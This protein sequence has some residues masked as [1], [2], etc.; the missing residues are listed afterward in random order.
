M[1]TRKKADSGRSVNL[2]S[3]T[4]FPM[5]DEIGWE[6]VTVDAMVRAQ[7]PE[8]WRSSDAHFVRFCAKY[9][10]PLGGANTPKP[11]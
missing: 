7:W 3:D 2:V 4:M 6:L 8:F 11:L 5:D 9:L 1:G 10:L